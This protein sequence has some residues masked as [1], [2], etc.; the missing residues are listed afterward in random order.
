MSK[1]HNHVHWNVIKRKKKQMWFLYFLRLFRE[2]WCRD[3]N[4]GIIKL[5]IILL[6]SIFLFFFLSLS[7]ITKNTKACHR[8]CRDCSLNF[9]RLPSWSVHNHLLLH[10]LCLLP[11]F[12]SFL[13]FFV[14]HPSLRNGP[15]QVLGFGGGKRWDFS[16]G[17][18][19]CHVKKRFFLSGFFLVCFILF[20]FTF[21]AFWDFLLCM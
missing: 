5:I 15:F 3:H 16:A 2:K 10:N 8:K 14:Q 6:Y 17:F 20:Y 1:F 9:G 4:L 7:L 13:P 19:A 18:C 21:F 11:P 12:S